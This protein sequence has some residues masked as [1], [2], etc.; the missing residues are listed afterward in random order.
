MPPIISSPIDSPHW[1]AAD[2]ASILAVRMLRAAT[3][4]RETRLLAATIA[5]S[6][7]V[8][9]VLGRFRFP[10]G[11]SI[12]VEPVQ[13][14]P[15]ARLASRAAF[16]DLSLAIGQLTSRVGPSLVVLRLSLVDHGTAS[17]A[18]PLPQ[19]VFV[20]GIRVRDDV[21]VARVPA[22]ARVEGVVGA[23]GATSVVGHDPV[24]ELALVRIPAQPAQVLGMRE[25]TTPLPAPGYVAMASASQGGVALQPLFVGRSD[26]QADPRWDVPLVTLGPGI[27]A[28]GGAPVFTLDGRLAGLTMPTDTGPGV[29]LVPSE[30]L[31]TAVDEIFAGAT[32][33]SGDIGV[34]TQPL[35]GRAARATGAPAGAVVS[36]VED[37]GPALD[38]LW[39]GDVITAVNGQPILSPAALQQRVRRA[40]PGT[41]L[42]LTVLRDGNY[43]SLPVKARA[44]PTPTTSAA[45]PADTAASDLGLTLRAEA[46][47]GAQVVR[48]RAGSA[49]DVA[50]LAAG[51][52]IHAV[53]RER[54]PS[55]SSV[56]QA[57][58]ALPGGG[59]VFLGVTR[60]GRPRAVV[61]GK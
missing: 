44:L 43:L 16:D 2:A 42:T 51:D 17:G 38:Q 45:A 10:D 48:V 7:L 53:G 30:A 56:Q 36:F 20:P 57:W 40:R 55:P 47:Q 39:V 23:P 14:Q 28:D 60:D 8:L 9:L 58:N 25:G 22:G 19:T 54:T 61:L 15:L 4:S 50:G 37:G 33:S 59:S 18:V 26:A 24:R 6:V 29:V 21:A 1:T 34:A 32:V 3:P 12:G 27:Q 49:A 13:S 5:V 46:G 35:D 11:P 41:S 52:L 31:M